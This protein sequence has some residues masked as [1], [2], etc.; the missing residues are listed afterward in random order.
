MAL[1]AAAVTLLVWLV[2][3]LMQD[4]AGE[5]KAA[6]V[7]TAHEQVGQRQDLPRPDDLAD[8]HTPGRIEELLDALPPAPG[9]E[10]HV[11][12]DVEPGGYPKRTVT[13]HVV[14]DDGGPIPAGLQL[15]A[16]WSRPSPEITD[17]RDAMGGLDLTSW[18]PRPRGALPREAFT[19]MTLADVG[20]DAAF[21][22][23]N[24]PIAGAFVRVH[25][26]HL[27][28]DPAVR[29]EGSGDAAVEVRLERGARI[30]GV[31]TDPQGKPVDD[32]E[33]VIASTFDPWMVFDSKSLMVEME[34]VETD[35]DGRFEVTQIPAGTR[36]VLIA[37]D[38]QNRWKPHQLDVAPLEPGEE[39]ALDL[40]LAL[41]ASISGSVVDPDGEPLPKLRVA[42]KKLDISLS[43][44]NVAMG[45]IA[46]GGER[47]DDE[48]RFKFSGLMDGAYKISLNED[49]FRR[50][51]SERL[52]V[53]SG[54]VVTD[55][56]LLAEAGLTLTG[57]VLDED[58][59][60]IERARIR[61]SRPV[62]MMNWT[63][64][65][66]GGHEPSTYS[67]EEGRFE[68]AGFDPGKIQLR[69]K[70]DGFETAK[71]T[72]DAGQQDIEVRLSST[73]GL[74]GIVVSLGDGEPVIRFTVSLMPEKG[75][76][77]L[78]DP[79]GMQER[80]L[81]A[82]RPQRFKDRE[83]G[84]FEIT[85]IVPGSYDVTVTG[86]GFAG[87]TRRAIQIGPEGHKGLVVMLPPE[88]VITGVVM[89]G[90]TGAVIS[91]ATIAT[92]RGGIME[93]LTASFGGGESRAVT[94]DEGRFR[95][96][97]LSS[98]PFSPSVQHDSYRKY[99]I[100]SLTLAPGEERDIGLVLLSKGGTVWGTVRDAQGASEADV[101]VMLSDA[102]GQTMKRSTTDERGG[103][104]IEGLAPGTYNVMRMDFKM[105]LGG[106]GGPMD[107][108]KD[109]VFNSVTIE[110]DEE[111]RVDLNR[112]TGDGTRVHGLVS[113]V[114]GPVKSAMVSL[115][116]ARGGVAGM[117][118]SSTNTEGRYEMTV[119]DPGD[120]VFTVVVM[121]DAMAAGSQ[122]SSP[123]V[124]RI[125]VSGLPEQREDVMLSG[126]SLHGT[127]ESAIDGKRLAGVRVI[128]ERTDEGRAKFGYLGLM[129]GRVGE[130]Y[131]DES[132]GFRFKYVPG[133]T[134][135]VVAGGTNLLDMGTAG[136]AVTRLDDVRVA[137]GATGFA[138]RIEV[139]PAGEIS[140][141]VTD[142]NGQP[143][144]GV[145]VWAMD[146]RGVWLST[147]SEVNTDIAGE[148]ALDSLDKGL[149]TLAFRDG[150]HGLKLVAGVE[151]RLGD[152]T[153]LDVT[154]QA[155]IVL[156]LALGGHDASDLDV[157]LIGPEGQVPIDLFS[158]FEVMGMNN[159]TEVQSLGTFPPGLYHVTVI[160][161]GS[162]LLDT[163]VTLSLSMGGKVEIQLDP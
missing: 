94:D 74:T 2:L 60:P 12:L 91:G 53:Q 130:T 84:T 127:V 9:I 8:E 140:G 33:I 159:L 34:G 152:P 76:F 89:D 111:K 16:S 138:V 32:V 85:D 100:S 65:L 146:S 10:G 102:M 106:D 75:L 132:G 15:S 46:S 112:G 56:E 162:M 125:T 148:Y 134:Y 82:Q 157:T 107:F 119:T 114:D 36:L 21:E 135:S 118:F 28:V 109:M 160:E 99:A 103:Y 11:H 90:V 44:I 95:L 129:A 156:E 83:D 92:T 79:F 96:G 51:T 66:E 105:D 113:S 143:L 6:E 38:D 122:P 62:S 153:T 14:I 25:H 4:G 61:A 98:T 86:E 19:E 133:G 158:M 116:P 29:L 48:G 101:M 104:R 161:G 123:M 39:R 139:R 93:T 41:G 69:V 144:S 68:L 115:T 78:T 50:S 18:F 27:Y 5:D 136:W 124:K 154:L 35:A 64:N 20:S 55:I 163:D 155:G 77:S 108:M 45:S 70:S 1:S 121:D 57:R 97:G 37:R 87:T 137:E 67:D 128:L 71:L 73:A 22:M 88:A 149:W 80:I 24:V 52:V 58:G 63:A 117:A 7:L 110:G 141:K 23:E 31:V 126:G 40:A 120:Y 17:L 30:H 151:V 43:A 142:T 147:F 3:Q 72:V 59:R 47:T 42:L 150:S 26:E 131:T 49:D 13:G 145:G 54:D 81:N